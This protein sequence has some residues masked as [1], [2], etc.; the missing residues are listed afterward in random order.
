MNKQPYVIKEADQ[1]LLLALGRFHYLTTAQV[2]RL[3][4]P[5]NS[6]DNR[7]VQRLLKR[8]VDAGYVLRLRALPPPLIG[9]AAHVFTLAGDG[10]KYLQALGVS[11]EQYFR[12][13]EERRTTENSPFMLHRLA[14]I[15]V[16]IAVDVLCREH[17]RVD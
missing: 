6:D 16:M 10:R 12:Q 15:D 17:P 1:K 5:N 13:S 9:R 7:Y 2:N 8:L 14:T 4:Y 11:V 3:L